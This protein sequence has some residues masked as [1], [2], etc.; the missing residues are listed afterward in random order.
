MKLHYIFSGT[1]RHSQ[2]VAVA[3]ALLER[4]G[5]R[6]APLASPAL[7]RL[8]DLCAGAFDAAQQ[9]EANALEALDD[10]SAEREEASSRAEAAMGAAIRALGPEAVLAELPL[11]LLEVGA[12]CA[13]AH[14]SERVCACA[15]GLSCC[16]ANFH[17][18]L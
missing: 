11:N 16:W 14:L 1:V 12:L 8:G 6:G 13:C 9:N 2:H 17:Q 15:P 3:T 5:R 4:L 10:E 7:V 18:K